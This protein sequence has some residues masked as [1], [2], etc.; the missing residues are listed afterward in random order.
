LFILLRRT[1]WRSLD[2]GVTRV[3]GAGHSEDVRNVTRCG[4]VPGPRPAAWSR[5]PDF[6]RDPRP[7]SA[8]RA[9]RGRRDETEK[10]TRPDSRSRE[11]VTPLAARQRGKGARREGQSAICNRQSAIRSVAPRAPA[12]VLVS[13][14]QPFTGCFFASDDAVRPF[15]EHR[16]APFDRR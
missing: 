3:D 7:S 16:R 4:E 13:P 9:I 15:A 2:E 10:K 6:P 5:R 14:C 8:G 1:V 12:V 11:D